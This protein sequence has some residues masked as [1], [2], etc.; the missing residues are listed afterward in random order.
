MIPYRFPF[1][2][3]TFAYYTSQLEFTKSNTDKYGSVFHMH[4][5][6]TINT[7]VGA[8]DAPEVFTNPDLSFT[9]SQAKVSF[10]VITIDLGHR[11]LNF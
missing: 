11:Q 8:Q 6:G 5:H 4:M 3:S 10:L 2:G 9:E 1:I 7:V